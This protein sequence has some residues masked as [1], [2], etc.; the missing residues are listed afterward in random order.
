MLW[1]RHEG[2]RGGRLLPGCVASGVG[3]SPTPDRPSFGACGRGPSPTGCGCGGCGRG[4]PPP[5]PQRAL[6]RAGFACCGGGMGVTLGGRLL[7]RC[8]APWVGRSPTPDHPSFGACGRGPLPTGC[9][10]GGSGRGDPL[11]TPQRALLRPGSARCG[12]GM[13]APGG[14]APCPCVGRPGSGALP[15]PAAR[16]LGAVAGAHY[17]LAVG[18]GGAGPGDPSPTPQRA[19][20]RAGFARCGG[21]TR[22]PPTPSPMGRAAGAHYPLAMDAGGCGRGDPSPTPQRA[23]LRADFACCAGG[24]RVPGGGGLL[25]QCGACGVG[26]SPN[27]GRPSFVACGRDPLPTECGCGGAGLGTCH[28]LH[29]GRSCGLA[30]RAVGAARGSPRPPVL[31]DVRPRPTTHWLWMRGAVGV[32]TRHQPY[33][34]L[35]QAGFARCGGGM[36]VPGGGASCL[37][38]G[39]PG[40]GALPLRAARPLWRAGGIHYP[41]SVGAG[42]RAW[43]PVTNSTAGA[44]ARWLCAL[45]GRHEGA[46]GGAPLAWVCVVRGR[47]LSQLRPPVLWGVRPGPATHWLW[48]WCAGAG[49]RLSLAPCP[50]PRFIVCCARPPGFCGTW[51]PLWLGI[52][53]RAVFVAGGVPLWRASWPRVGALRLVRSGRSRCSG[54]LSR[55]RGAFYHPVGCRPWLYKVAARGTWRPAENRAHC[56]C[57][58]PLPRQGRWA[59]SVSYR[60]VG[61][62]WGCPWRVPLPSVLGC[63]RY[64]GL[65]CV[66]PVTDASGF[67]YRP[68][69]HGGLGRCT[70]AV[71]CG[72]QH[73]PFRVGGR[74]ARV[75][76]AC[77][78]VRALLGRVGRAGLPGAFWCASPFLRPFCPSSLFGPLQAGVALA[79]GVCFLFGLLFPCLPPSPRAPPLPPLFC[80]SWPRLPWALAFAPTPPPP[81]VSFFFSFF[82][83]V[84][85]LL[86]RAFSAPLHPL[87]PPGLFVFAPFF[88]PLS[89]FSAFFFM[90][91]S[92]SGTLPAFLCVAAFGAPGLGA[93]LC[94]PPPAPFFPPLRFFV[95]F[96]FC[97]SF[98]CP[99]LASPLASLGCGVYWC[100]SLW[101]LCPG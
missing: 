81:L 100:V 41:L 73:L 3:R 17:P 101:A 48:L 15:S 30:L 11:P 18:G 37:C 16:P 47:A 79:S 49:A 21:G 54:R 83:P 64:G 84:V 82:F 92:P 19:L 1:G 7:S 24:T 88:L 13:S 33:S 86:S 57:R 6:L 8:G 96:P 90:V 69:V 78:C 66:D 67:A 25:S 95:F 9:G 27:P 60:F 32:G 91:C 40:L 58:W 71:S 12:G 76:R 22:E 68:S 94:P 20:W 87:A 77:V 70:G 35:L 74:H 89:S 72:R 65:A 99:L 31:W 36:R 14:G 23:L 50:V 46:L 63:V 59:R 55:R 62:R 4:D 2:V 34:A 38:V 61:P 75:P 53:R 39:R 29:S 42:V 28:Q 98:C 85:L 51:W 45:W 43:G 26:C 80:A 93:L 44:L 56:A 52:C 10:C 97:S 5:T